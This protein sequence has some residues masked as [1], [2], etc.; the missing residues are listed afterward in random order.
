MRFL[1]TRYRLRNTL[2]AGAL[3]IAGAL[4]VFLY[5]ASYR[6]DVES[7]AGLVDVFVAAKDIPEGLDGGTVAGGGYLRKESVLRRNVIE[8]AIATPDR[9]AGLATSQTI[10][11]GEQVTTRQFHPAAE[12]GV[13]ANISGNRRAVKLSGDANALLSGIVDDGDHVDVMANIT[14]TI[15]TRNSSSG[16]LRRVATRI[17]LRNL[18]VLEAPS[19]ET[20]GGLGGQNQSAITLAL[21]D[22]Q[23]QKLMYA[24]EN[25]EWWLLLR[26]VAR[27][28]DSPESVETIESI[29]G[30]G[31]GQRGIDQLTSGYGAGSI[32]SGE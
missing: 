10:L 19:G 27:P 5:V 30:E 16:D 11:A 28:A 13:L 7:G 14:F 2:I 32:S 17:I 8:G 20:D 31:L 12:Q 26:P 21:T 18:L 3:A 6:D 25:G 22:F 4:L 9:I 23:A 24:A 29:L 1:L 15:R